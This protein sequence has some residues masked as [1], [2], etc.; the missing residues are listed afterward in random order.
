MEKIKS[1]FDLY[2]RKETGLSR[3]LLAYFILT[4]G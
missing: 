3:T 1:L 2:N 4:I